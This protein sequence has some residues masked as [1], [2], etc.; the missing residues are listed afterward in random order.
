M[1][2]R[3]GAVRGLE[4]GVAGSPVAG[5][6][7]LVDRIHPRPHRLVGVACA[8]GDLL[9]PAERV[10]RRL[11][12]LTTRLAVASTSAIHTSAARGAMVAEVEGQPSRKP[13]R[14]AGC[15]GQPSAKFRGRRLVSQP[16]GESKMLKSWVA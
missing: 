14:L 11:G 7:R 1:Q 8:F 10:V 15:G 9:G 16:S 13:A 4:L 5:Y 12:I 6:L 3:K 2:R